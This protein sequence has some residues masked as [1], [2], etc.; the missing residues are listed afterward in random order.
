MSNGP[1]FPDNRNFYFFGKFDEIRGFKDTTMN[2]PNYIYV[3]YEGD[4]KKIHEKTYKRDDFLYD[5][6]FG[7]IFIH[8][9]NNKY[10]NFIISKDKFIKNIRTSILLTEIKKKKLF[11]TDIKKN[12]WN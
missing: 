2:D 12:L 1:Q 3:L 6:E 4:D 8:N 11:L 10:I 5:Y 9:S 7:K